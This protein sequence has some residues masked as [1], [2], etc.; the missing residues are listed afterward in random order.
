MDHLAKMMR[1]NGDGEGARRVIDGLIA[2]SSDSIAA[3]KAKAGICMK[4]GLLDEA[5]EA[6]LKGDRP[7][8]RKS[9]YL[10]SGPEYLRETE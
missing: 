2:S 9:F 7:W 6:I 1:L 5:K 8:R 3:Y 4:N 10:C